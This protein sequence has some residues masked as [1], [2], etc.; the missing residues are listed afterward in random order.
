MVFCPF[1]PFVRRGEGCQGAAGAGARARR[2]VG[3]EG[4]T[5]HGHTL[6]TAW[7]RM[8]LR[9]FASAPLLSCCLEEKG[10]SQFPSLNPHSSQR[11]SGQTWSTDTETLEQGR[12]RQGSGR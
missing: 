11:L 6:D 12:C 2:A 5:R 7:A 10:R 1:D 3:R 8:G 4:E 9:G